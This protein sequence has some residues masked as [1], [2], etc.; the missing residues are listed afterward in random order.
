MADWKIIKFSDR[1]YI[2]IHGW[3]FHSH[4]SLRGGALKFPMI[5]WAC[6]MSPPSTIPYLAIE[7]WRFMTS[8]PK[9]IV[10]V[11]SPSSIND[12][13]IGSIYPLP[14][15]ELTYS[16]WG[17]GKSSTQKCR[18]GGYVS[19]LEGTDQAFLLPSGG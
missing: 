8:D 16:T 12:H 19:S 14:S 18:L 6:R 3:V 4:V 9:K 11:R 5:F 17:K 7:G 10:L 2:F 13:T 1:K 15:R